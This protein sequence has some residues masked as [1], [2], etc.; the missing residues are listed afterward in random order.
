M[1]DGDFD[2]EGREFWLSAAEATR[3]AHRGIA[4]LIQ[5]E[6]KNWHKNLLRSPTLRNVGTGACK[7]CTCGISRAA[8]CRSCLKNCSRC[9]ECTEIK[10]ELQSPFTAEEKSRLCW[11]N[12]ECKQWRN[13]PWEVAKVFMEPLGLRAKNV[14]DASSTDIKG[15]LS[16]LDRCPFTTMPV[17][18]TVLEKVR[19]ARNMWAHEPEME[20]EEEE[21]NNF[22]TDIGELLEDRVFHNDDDVKKA[23]EELEKLRDPDQRPKIFRAT[24][25]DYLKQRATKFLEYAVGK[26]KERLE[27]GKSVLKRARRGRYVGTRLCH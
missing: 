19:D 11:Q 3:I 10:A 23:L 24:R 8:T 2:T 16:L 18:K 17:N 4:P 15:I 12:S 9:K 1:T 7:Q 5:R 14:K 13:E 21:M 25:K 20:M 27:Y 26:D 6:F 22:F